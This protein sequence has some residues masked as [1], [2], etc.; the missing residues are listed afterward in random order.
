L[1]RRNDSKDEDR[2]G[3]RVQQRLRTEAT[4]HHDTASGHGRTSVTATSATTL[5]DVF[6]SSTTDREPFA[7]NPRQLSKTHYYRQLRHFSVSAVF[8]L[9]EEDLG[10][11][12][13]A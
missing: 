4:F 10:P 6:N 2:R 13:G 11:M 12:L 1:T 3:G 8:A 5:R 7:F 9:R